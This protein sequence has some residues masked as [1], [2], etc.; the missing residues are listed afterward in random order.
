MIICPATLADLPRL[1]A[2]ENAVFASDRISRRQFRYL[3]TK[4][5]ALVVKAVDG[6]PA[7]GGAL[8]GY[9]VLLFRRN[10][11]RTRI[12]SLAVA[13]WARRRGLARRFLAY[14][15]EESRRRNLKGMTL[16]VREDNAA[17][18]ALYQSVGYTLIGWRQN[19]C[20]DGAAAA[21][22]G[23]MLAETERKFP[24]MAKNINEPCPARAKR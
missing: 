4:G 24:T 13:P 1:A 9:L 15:E 20:E 10:S 19:Y 16:E 17:A 18:Q 11:G 5:R 8:A 23:K 7:D 2:L 12:Y 6:D 14:A 22:L 3:L 21:R